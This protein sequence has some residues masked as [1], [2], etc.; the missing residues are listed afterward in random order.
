MAN[1]VQNGDFSA[2]TANWLSTGGLVGITGTFFGSSAIQVTQPPFEGLLSQ[3]I[4][5]TSVN[6]GDTI[7]IA[8]Y[9]AAAIDTSTEAFRGG[10]NFAAWLNTTNSITGA[11][12]IDGSLINDVNWPLTNTEEYY[13]QEFTWTVTTA[14]KNNGSI[15]LIFNIGNGDFNE[16]GLFTLTEVWFS[17]TPFCYNEGTQILCINRA[18]NQEEYRAIENIR[19]GDLVQT[20]KRGP[21]AVTQIGKGELMNS[22][23]NPKCC[24]YKL[25]KSDNMIDDL[26]ITG[27]HSIL[28]DSYE[29][30]EDEQLH[31][32]NHGRDARIEDKRL[33]LARLSSKFIRL[34]EGEK[35]TYYQFSLDNRGNNNFHYGVWANGVLSES[36]SED[37]Y[38]THN[39]TPLN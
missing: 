28:V 39:L 9:I 8:Y 2:G 11:T 17:T 14:A 16:D 38:K 22:H 23:T 19:I 26:I 15:F 29:S 7:N 37:V 24:M 6:V 33:L 10:C 20:Y 34:P 13:L 25:P 3:S 12:P 32:A 4:D 36:C 18:T 27:N 1:L 35:Y 31:I 30:R 21:R 5:L